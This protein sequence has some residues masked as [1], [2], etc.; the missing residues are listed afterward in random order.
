MARR[1]PKAFYV[2]LSVWAGLLVLWLAL[3]LAGVLHGSPRYILF[4]FVMGVGGYLHTLPRA[5]ELVVRAGWSAF[6]EAC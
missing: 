5:G 4:A 3:F 6:S 2:A 1:E